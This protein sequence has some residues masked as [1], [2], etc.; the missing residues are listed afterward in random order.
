MSVTIDVTNSVGVHQSRALAAT[1][2]VCRESHLRRCLNA[3]V[4]PSLVTHLYSRA[5]RYE[6]QRTSAAVKTEAKV[7]IISTLRGFKEE[8]LYVDRESRVRSYCRSVNAIFDTASG[9]IMRDIDGG[10]YIDFPSSACSL[11]YGHDDF[12]MIAAGR[13]HRIPAGHDAR[14]IASGDARR[15]DKR[16]DGAPDTALRSGGSTAMRIHAA[17]LLEYVYVTVS[18]SGAQIRNSSGLRCL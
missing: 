5:A 9:S 13:Y 1:N 15:G 12:Q 18:S 7:P 11:K 2:L 14:R 6:K 17:A 8:K 16:A 4:F 3:V 10:K